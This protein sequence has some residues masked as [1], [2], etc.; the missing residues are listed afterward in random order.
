MEILGPLKFSLGPEGFKLWLS[1]NFLKTSFVTL[2][3][4]TEKPLRDASP[5]NSSVRITS[6]EPFGVQRKCKM[7]YFSFK[8]MF[9]SLPDIKSL[10]RMVLLKSGGENANN[11]SSCVNS[12]E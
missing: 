11:V 12:K 7:E 5:A 1:S 6:R 9:C 8:L 2:Y 3:T 4:R 10:M